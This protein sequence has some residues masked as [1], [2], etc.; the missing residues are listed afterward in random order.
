LELPEIG[1]VCQVR[2]I[3]ITRHLAHERVRQALISLLVRHFRLEDMEVE[4]SINVG[5]SS[6]KVDVAVFDTGK[7]HTQ[8]NIILLAECKQPNMKPGSKNSGLGQLRSYMSACPNCEHGVWAGDGV[9]ML[10]RRETDDGMIN[11]PVVTT[12]YPEDLGEIHLAPVVSIVPEMDKKVPLTVAGYRAMKIAAV[13]GKSTDT[14]NLLMLRMLFA[15]GLRLGE[16]MRLTPG[17]VSRNGPDTSISIY[18]NKSNAKQWEDVP[19]EATVGADLVAY[20]RGNNIPR[21][22]PVFNITRRQAQN[23][24]QSIGQRALNRDV[25]SRDFRKLYIQ[26]LMI[27]GGVPVEVVAKMVGHTNTAT[28]MK[29]YFDLTQEQRKEINQSIPV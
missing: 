28:T 12:G 8:T 24:I 16:V 7:P 3:S 23:I 14:R 25:S 26:T 13:E 11:F 19:I 5:S 10:E 6:R 9:L 20:I 18:R 2:G 27:Q 22:R 4:F 21:G 29:Y 15:T 17:H 1:L